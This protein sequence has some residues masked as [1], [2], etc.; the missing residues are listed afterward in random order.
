MQTKIDRVAE[1]KRVGLNVP[2]YTLFFDHKIFKKFLNSKKDDEKISLR[3]YSKRDE[4]REFKNPFFPN[5]TVK[6]I[7]KH[8]KSLKDLNVIVS[9]PINPEESLWVGNIGFSSSSEFVLEAAKGPGTVRELTVNKKPSHIIKTNLQDFLKDI[10]ESELQEV[11]ITLAQSGIYLSNRIFE[12]SI[13]GSK[14]GCKKE[15]IIWWEFR[16]FQ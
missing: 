9:S 6:E 10:K 2:D 1:M 8:L 14:V 3:S 12:F 7:K 11:I 13:Y 16:I 5:T 4:I 15:H